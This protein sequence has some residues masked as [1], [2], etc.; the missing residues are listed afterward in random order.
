LKLATAENPYSD[1]VSC[2][3]KCTRVERSYEY[4]KELCLDCKIEVAVQQQKQ[5]ESVKEMINE[6]RD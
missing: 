1:I 4:R 6:K 5:Y 2:N 3:K